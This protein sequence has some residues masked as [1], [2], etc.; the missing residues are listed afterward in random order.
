MRTATD[1]LK[2]DHVH[3]LRLIAVMEAITQMPEPNTEHVETIVEL[4]RNFADGLHHNKE[5]NLLFPKM[6]EKGFSFEKGPV[7]VMMHEHEQGRIFTKGVAENM[8]LY[9]T[10]DLRAIADVY[11]NMLG[12]AELLTAHISKENN[13]LFR[14]ADNALSEEEQQKLLSEFE[15]AELNPVCGGLVKDCIDQIDKLARAYHLE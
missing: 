4:I 6:A 14:M 3:I 13:I 5:E 10:G 12:Y 2:N 7:A 11:K 15:K 9:K 8:E 1:N